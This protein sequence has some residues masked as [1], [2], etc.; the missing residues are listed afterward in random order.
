M[1]AFVVH[2]EHI[3]VLLWAASRPV[4]HDGP[5]QWHFDNPTK[6]DHLTRDRL[7]GVGQMLLDANVASVNYR[8]GEDDESLAYVYRPPQHSTWTAPEL[9][10]AV[11][12]Y[13]YQAC[14]RPDWQASEAHAFCRALEHR[15]IQSLPGY[16]DGPWSITP[17]D[18]PAG[19]RR[20]GAARR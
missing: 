1:S 15:L 3:H 17:T 12:C 20:R 16:D 18:V 11:H 2:P 10:N 4:G 7:D 19:G 13:E 6:V 8:Y 14:E 9:L 5:L